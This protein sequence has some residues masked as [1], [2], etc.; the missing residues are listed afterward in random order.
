VLLY[1]AVYNI[2]GSYITARLAPS[3][4]MRLAIIVGVLG[5]IASITGAIVT[6]DMNL[7]PA[8][9][10]WTLALISTPSSWIGA[11]MF[12]HRK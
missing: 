10:P 12:L 3:H 11:K 6:R 1:R 5:T 8:W 2:I 4:P 7:G 9:Y